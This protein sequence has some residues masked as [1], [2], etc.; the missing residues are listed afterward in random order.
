MSIGISV[1][2]QLC[3][4]L[5]PSIISLDGYLTVTLILQTVAVE[6]KNVWYQRWMIGL[7]CLGLASWQAINT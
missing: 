2:V 7:D 4:S 5:H 6:V 1:R 3:G